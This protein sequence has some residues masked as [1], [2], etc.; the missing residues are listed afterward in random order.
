ML[1][2]TPEAVKPPARPEILAKKLEEPV[3]V[4]R[5]VGG[6]VNLAPSRYDIEKEKNSLPITVGRGKEKRQTNLVDHLKEDAV[7]QK[8]LE[9]G[10]QNNIITEQ[11]LAARQIGKRLVTDAKGN[12]TFRFSDRFDH[13]Q[14]TEAL[15]LL[16]EKLGEKQRGEDGKLLV[17]AP[18]F[19]EVLDDAVIKPIKQTLTT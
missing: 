18:T 1:D 8:M 15:V 6:N 3:N 4:E 5:S 9:L 16:K 2:S 13:E 14:K 19:L 10:I 11:E 12:P 17:A 7:L